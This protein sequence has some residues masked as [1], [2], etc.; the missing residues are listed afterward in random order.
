MILFYWGNLISLYYSPKLFCLASFVC[1]II[2]KQKSYS[3]KY[4]PDTTKDSEHMPNEDANVITI[5]A[6]T[7]SSIKNTLWTRSQL[8]F[9]RFRVVVGMCIGR[10]SKICSRVC[11]IYTHP[12][13]Y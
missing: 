12:A 3:R 11:G 1:E 2:H 10:Y 4:E 5:I 7:N 8:C 9:G 13:Y 6:R